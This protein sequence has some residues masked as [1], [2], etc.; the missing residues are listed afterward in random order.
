MRSVPFRM[1]ETLM[2]CVCRDTSSALALTVLEN[3]AAENKYAQSIYL[4]Y[5]VP[6]P[7]FM[8][9]WWMP[10]TAPFTKSWARP[11]RESI[12]FPYI[13]VARI[14]SRHIQIHSAQQP[15]SLENAKWTHLRQNN[16]SHSQIPPFISVKEIS[17]SPF[18]VIHHL[19]DR[20]RC[21][22][23]PGDGIKQPLH[24]QREMRM[25]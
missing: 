15:R 9:S 2:S 10:E 1:A 16:P 22:R 5:H 25:A 21:S 7:V 8:W 11:T 18:L 19:T 20:I 24:A 23:W 14:K 3:L 13:I 4:P 6:C 17:L 12:R